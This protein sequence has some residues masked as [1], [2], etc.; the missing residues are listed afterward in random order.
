M[1]NLSYI[2][3]TFNK[4]DYLKVTLPYL[5]EACQEDEEIVVVD[6]G[7]TDGTVD[8]LEQ[9]KSENKIHQLISEKDYGEAHGT[10][11]AMLLATGELIKI[12]TDD[13]AFHF[14]NINRCK[15]FMLSNNTIDVL[16]SNGYYF[17]PSI[18]TQPEWVQM[19]SFFLTWKANRKPFLF[20]GLSLMVRRSSLSL[21]GL[22]D[23]NFM[24][25]D[26]EYTLR[27]T[28]GKAHVAWFAGATFLNIIN[29]QSN[30]NKYLKRLK[31][32]K[33]K[34][35]KFYQLDENHWK[36]NYFTVRSF[37]SVSA[38]K[39]LGIKQKGFTAFDYPTIFYSANKLME[40]N[41]SKTNFYR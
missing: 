31:A 34:L 20:S 19:D 28:S 4:L 17:N 33:K 10:N 8:F 21:L 11:K 32:E 36:E 9:L 24:I 23:T 35:L 39:I 41:F 38:R 3:T 30:S 37:V 27:I 18:S 5:I 2:L 12:I 7:S 1:I 6:G 22:L 16:G 26:F 25:V 29:P 13:D 15:E 14:Q 40:A